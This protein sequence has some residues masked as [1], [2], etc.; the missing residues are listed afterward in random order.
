MAE[1]TEL[2]VLTTNKQCYVCGQTRE[3][4]AKWFLFFVVLFAFLAEDADAI[5]RRGRARR[6]RTNYSS[7]NYGYTFTATTPQE[8]AEQKAS[9]LAERGY[10]FHP[11][12]GY[13]G[14]Y[15]EGWGT[16][17][18]AEQA[19]WST[20]FGDEC[21]SARGSAQAWSEKAGIWFSINIW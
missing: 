12:G 11:G 14:G 3:L 4:R 17:A 19:K 16:G 7:V 5:G 6:Y 20:C 13:A 1:R 8:L 10:G 15:R 18:T 9:L 2:S 21:M